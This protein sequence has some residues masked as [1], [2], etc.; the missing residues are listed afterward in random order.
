MRDR[1]IEWPRPRQVVLVVEQVPRVMDHEGDGLGDI[2]GRA[3]A[4]PDDGIGLVGPKSL[5]ARD[6]LRGYQIAENLRV[7]RDGQASRCHRLAERRV[8]RQLGDAPIG[9]DQRA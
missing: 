7:R 3:T 2:D 1:L 8:Q 5:D 4:E 9:D 6:Y